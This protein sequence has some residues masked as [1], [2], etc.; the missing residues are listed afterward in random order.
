VTKEQI[1][2]NYE[3]YGDQYL[4][5]N[6]IYKYWLAI[7]PA[8]ARKI[9]VFYNDWKK[10]NEEAVKKY[11]KEKSELCQFSDNEWS[12]D[13]ELYSFIPSELFK[14]KQFTRNS[15]LLKNY[16][17]KEY[18]V[19]IFDV[20]AEGSVPPIEYIE[21]KIEKVILNNRKQEIIKRVKEQLYKKQLNA[22]NVKIYVNN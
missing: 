8:K 10:G 7:V 9:E 16:K 20:V 19:K 3:N 21:A 2:E 4:L 15:T 5:S 1:K 17:G 14:S 13:A 6:K 11:C 12:T 18:F 22:K